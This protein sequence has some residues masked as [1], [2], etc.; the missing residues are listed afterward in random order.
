MN[1]G[2]SPKFMRSSGITCES[3]SADS[4]EC[5]E[6]TS[7][8]KPTAFLPIRRA[9]ILSSPANAP[10]QMKRMFVVSMVRNS[11]CGCLRPPCGGTEAIVP[12]RI[13]RSACCTP[14]PDTSLRDRRVVGLAGDL[15]DLVDVDDPRLRLLDVEVGGLDQLE[16]DV[17]DVLA[18]VARPR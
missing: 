9:M 11:W 2:I 4:S 7:A 5:F 1:S 16:E 3:S 18:D 13:F 17:L 15:V 12:S 8:P 14:S 10:P 6:R